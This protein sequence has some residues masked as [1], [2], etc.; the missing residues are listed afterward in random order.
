[1]YLRQNKRSLSTVVNNRQRQ[2]NYRNTCP[3][4]RWRGIFLPNVFYTVS[5]KK[6]ARLKCQ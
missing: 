1:M 2:R 5:R 4:A 3:V 6:A